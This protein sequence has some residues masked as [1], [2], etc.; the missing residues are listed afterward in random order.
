MSL[1]LETTQ[2]AAFAFAFAFIDLVKF[3]DRDSGILI[4]VT[5]QNGN[6][7]VEIS[8]IAMSCVNASRKL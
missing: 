6:N 3:V 4:M 2:M 5:L 7:E 1:S 8:C